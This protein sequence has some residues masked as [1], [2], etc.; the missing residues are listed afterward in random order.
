MKSIA[1][2]YSVYARKMT[3]LG[4]YPSSFRE[5]LAGVDLQYYTTD[6]ITVEVNSDNQVLIPRG[7]LAESVNSCLVILNKEEQTSNQFS[8]VQRKELNTIVFNDLGFNGDY[9][10]VKLVGRV[11]PPEEESTVSITLLGTGE[12]CEVPIRPSYLPTITDITNLPKPIQYYLQLDELVDA[13][14]EL[15]A[16]VI[17]KGVV[18]IVLNIKKE[19]GYFLDEG[20]KLILGKALMLQAASSDNEEEEDIF[21]EALDEELTDVIS[22]LEK[23]VKHL[24]IDIHEKQLEDSLVVI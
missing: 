19:L 7:S 22:V 4:L 10:N 17:A 14:N 16:R 3:N 20:F 24:L 18:S 6:D 9:S 21:T 1:G 2:G 8:I 12:K 13:T 15:S 23:L 11:L 5:L